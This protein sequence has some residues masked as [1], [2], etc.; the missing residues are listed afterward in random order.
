[1]DNISYPVVNG[2]LCSW[3]SMSLNLGISGGGAIEVI[4]F[5]AISYKAK[6]TRE[7]VRGAGR[8][9]LGM[10]KGIVEF[11]DPSLTLIKDNYWDIRDA[12][13]QNGT[14]GYMDAVFGATVQYKEDSTG[15]LHTDTLFGARLGEED[16]DHTQGT[17]G[18]EVKFTLTI[19][20]WKG[21]NGSYHASGSA[22]V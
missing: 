4:G 7:K 16:H 14:I 21:D 22:G 18:L 20:G 13:G 5:K 8:H 1:M 17:A 10:T 19:I 9:V 12:L 3:A 6:V 2:Y 15:I 11:D